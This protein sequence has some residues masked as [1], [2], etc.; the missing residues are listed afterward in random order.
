MA[1]RTKYPLRTMEIG[2]EFLVKDR[3]WL[4]NIIWQRGARLGRRFKTKRIGDQRRVK[5]IA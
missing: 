2:E 5:R 1:G 4:P 3:K